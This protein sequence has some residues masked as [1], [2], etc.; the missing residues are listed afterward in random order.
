[1]VESRH[2][3]EM[4]GSADRLGLGD[5]DWGVSALPPTVHL[6]VLMYAYFLCCWTASGSYKLL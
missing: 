1:M 2:V 5:M 4:E 6:P 3:W